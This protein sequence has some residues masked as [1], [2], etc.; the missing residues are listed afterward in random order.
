MA[1]GSY[2]VVGCSVDEAVRAAGR[3]ARRVYRVLSGP[4]LVA[5]WAA[6]WDPG[7]LAGLRASLSGEECLREAEWLVGVYWESPYARGLPA[8]EVYRL[9]VEA[10]PLPYLVAYPMKKSPEWYLL[11]FEE[12]RRIM[13][14]HIRI[15]REAE[16]RVGVPVRS[17]TTYAFGLAA[18]EFLVIYEVADLAGWARIVEEL[19]GAEARRWVVREEPVITGILAGRG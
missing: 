10:E 16:K 5:V 11:P 19:R 3:A 18:H 15:A 9:A 17:Y 8:E 1:V 12:R 4:G 6:S 2:D 13:A 7:D 14:E